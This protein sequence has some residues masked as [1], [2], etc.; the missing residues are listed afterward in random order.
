MVIDSHSLT[1]PLLTHLALS[2]SITNAGYHWQ[3]QVLKEGGAAASEGPRREPMGAQHYGRGYPPE[4]PPP[5]GFS[6]QYFSV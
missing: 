2:F 6:L 5:A 4:A 3:I 1:Q